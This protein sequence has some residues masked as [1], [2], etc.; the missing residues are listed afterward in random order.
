MF[1]RDDFDTIICEMHCLP[2]ICSKHCIDTAQTY[3]TND[4]CP[5]TNSPLVIADDI[6]PTNSTTATKSATR[7]TSNTQNLKRTY[8][9]IL[10][11]S[12]KTDFID[13][14]TI[15]SIVLK[16]ANG[17]L[18]Y[19]YLIFSDGVTCETPQYHAFFDLFELFHEII[20]DSVITK[21]YTLTKL[22]GT[23]LVMCTKY[24][25][26][27]KLLSVFMKRYIEFFTT[28]HKITEWTVYSNIPAVSAT[29][30]KDVML[31][32]QQ[33]RQCSSVSMGDI[34]YTIAFKEAIERYIK[35]KG[36]SNQ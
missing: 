28:Q 35:L 30:L 8:T 20:K 34:S 13:Y 26:I 21:K 24:S 6:I 7:R 31:P 5:Y 12:E 36:Y 23:N 14:K 1:V 17:M 29:R 27:I 19:E 3:G 22:H 25:Y 9:S 32:F 4:I 33:S 15:K 10:Q 11:K 18:H 16:G 2:H